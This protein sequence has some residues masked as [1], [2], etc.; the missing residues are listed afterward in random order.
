VFKECVSLQ[1]CVDELH[2]IC[3]HSH[4]HV[5]HIAGML[6]DEADQGLM[7]GS[8]IPFCELWFINQENF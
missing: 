6:K 8:A 7:L 1:T 3:V 2:Y 5:S 4:L